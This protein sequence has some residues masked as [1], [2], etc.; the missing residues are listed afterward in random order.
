MLQV[1]GIEPFTFT[2]IN[3]VLINGLHNYT[4]KKY[5]IFVKFFIPHVYFISLQDYEVSSKQVV[6]NRK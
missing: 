1:L 4:I 2:M 3:Q 5:L 6:G